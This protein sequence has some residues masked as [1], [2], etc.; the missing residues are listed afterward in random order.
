MKY[1]YPE[2]TTLDTFYTGADGYLITPEELPF[3]EYTMVE[4]QAPYGYVLDS[5]PI[6]SPWRRKTPPR[7][8]AS[9]LW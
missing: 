9:P 6:R 3:G 1:T 2:V 8:A 4:V 5:T 7:K